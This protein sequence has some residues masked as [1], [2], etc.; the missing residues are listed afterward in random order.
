MLDNKLELA[1]T[2]GATHVINGANGVDVVAEVMK[3]CPGGVE[4]AFDA[5]GNSKVLE[6]IV[7]MLRPGGAAIEV[8]IA[9]MAQM[10]SINPFS[11]AI[12]E[13]RILGSLYGSARPQ[14]DMP[15]ILSLYKQGRCKLDELISCTLPLDKINDGFDMLRAGSVARAVS[16]S[17]VALYRSLG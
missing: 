11:L 4:F 14:V 2:F 8:G 16:K 5:I 6:Q 1:K 17:A 13:K 10:A 3:L 15:R 12:Q 9:P 7:N